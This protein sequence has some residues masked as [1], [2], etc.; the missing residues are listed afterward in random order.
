MVLEYAAV[1]KPERPSRRPWPGPRY[2]ADVP[3]RDYLGPGQG[4]RLGRSLT[5]KPAGTCE[6]QKQPQPQL[7]D[8]AQV[9]KNVYKVEPLDNINNETRTL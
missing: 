5:N 1:P 2:Q 3:G 7:E 9:Y 8:K 6:Q 4:R